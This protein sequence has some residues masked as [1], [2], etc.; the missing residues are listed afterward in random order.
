[1]YRARLADAV[2]KTIRMNQQFLITLSEGAA[3][4]P[5]FV[6][7][8]NSIASYCKWI[9]M[10]SLP[11]GDYAAGLQTFKAHAGT[12]YDTI[13]PTYLDMP[14]TIVSSDTQI[15]NNLNMLLS[16]AQ[17]LDGGSTPALEQQLTLYANQL[18]KTLQ[19]LQGRIS[20][21]SQAVTAF[22]NNL[23][24]DSNTA[25]NAMNNMQ[26]QIAQDNNQLSQLYGRLHSLQNAT[27]PDGGQ[28][29]DCSKQISNE[30]AQINSLRQSQNLYDQV[31]SN[32]SQA[33]NGA[34][35]LASFWQG[36]VVDIQNCVISL[37][38]IPNETGVILKIDLQANQ[39]NWQ[40]LEAELQQISQ[41][42]ST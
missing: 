42:I 11:A 33:V 21:L 34:N 15:N 29:S 7:A 41:Q 24:S 32:A 39:A 26:N 8:A 16:L 35:Y 9:V 12:W 6:Q 27:C 4:T 1:M 40:R 19:D 3:L 36:I 37:Q 31:N 20:S 25:R 28:I 30:Q 18:I 23:G 38:R 22:A 17:Q 2:I 13:Y 5:S 14:A 10:Q